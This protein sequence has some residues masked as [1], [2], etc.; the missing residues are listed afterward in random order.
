MTPTRLAELRRQFTGA[1]AGL[2]GVSIELICEE[3][4]DALE[5]LVTLLATIQGPVGDLTEAV[6][7]YERS[8]R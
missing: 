4:L 8:T 2:V 3:A 5:P 7:E 6:E 1:R